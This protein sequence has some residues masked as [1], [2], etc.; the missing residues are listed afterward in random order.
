MT[1][2][3]RISKTYQKE[4]SPHTEKSLQKKYMI[5]MKNKRKRQIENLFSGSNHIKGN[6]RNGTIIVETNIVR[7]KFDFAP[8]CNATI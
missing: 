4:K 8:T 3:K 1:N 6:P 5:S 7:R 2:K